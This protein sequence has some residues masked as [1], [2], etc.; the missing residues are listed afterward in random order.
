MPSGAPSKSLSALNALKTPARIRENK[1]TSRLFSRNNNLQ[2]RRPLGI[3]RYFMPREGGSGDDQQEKEE[4]RRDGDR[5]RVHDGSE[6]GRGETVEETLA[7]DSPKTD[8]STIRSHP[9]YVPRR[10]VMLPVYTDGSCINN[11]K[12]GAVGGIG[13]F[14]GHG[15]TRNVSECVEFGDDTQGKVTNQTAELLACV[16]AIERGLLRAPDGITAV[17]PQAVKGD[18]IM[19]IYTDSEYVAKAMNTWAAGWATNG[20][21]TANGRQVANIGLMKT[22][23]DLKKRTGTRFQH[24]P[25]HGTEPRD[26]RSMAHAHWEGNKMADEFATAASARC[27]RAKQQ[28]REHV[29]TSIR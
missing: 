7:A 25:A 1:T 8:E 19:T 18:I 3:L 23:Y 26:C 22:L 6:T 14:F 15:D 24:V 4:R 17:S 10:P 29:K 5:D 11:G 27:F 21:K 9:T 2:D 28:R 20:W 16:R 13:V 12:R